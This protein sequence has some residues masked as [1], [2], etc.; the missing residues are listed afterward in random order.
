MNGKWSYPTRVLALLLLVG[1][2]LWL[3]LALSPLLKAVSVAA[4][5]AYLL[6][7]LVRLVRERMMLG[8]QIAAL[9]VL[10]LLLL[11]LLGIPALLGTVAVNQVSR[12]EA[13]LLAAWRELG[14]WL[15]RPVSVLGFVFRPEEAFGSLQEMAVEALGSLQ[16]SA[17]ALLSG[18]TLNVLW[19]LVIVV[20]LYYFLR[21]G[22]LI[23][24]WLLASLPAPY[25]PEAAR[26]LREVN[27][28]WGQFLR[29]QL[30]MFALLGSLM[31]AGTWLIVALFRTG[32]LRWSPLGFVL[33]LLL[34]YTGLQQLDNLWLRPRILGRHLQLHPALVF[35][36]LV[37]GVIVAGLLGAFVSVPL[38]ATVRVAGKYVHRKLLGLPGWADG[39]P[40]EGGPPAVGLGEGQGNGAAREPAPG[41]RQVEGADE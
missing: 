27:E 28:V 34:L 35:L 14:A 1:A 4:L 39:P 23:K 7:P 5:L 11:L 9:A 25:R 21:D 16:G 24:P 6:H 20:M 8:R 33:L 22:H 15:L 12:F 10:L 29:I 3:A 41:V 13:D 17:L 38:I 30:I 32:L 18:V 40:A 36:G 2:G 19:G 31:A 26:L 37:G